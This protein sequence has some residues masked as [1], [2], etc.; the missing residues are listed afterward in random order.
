MIESEACHNLDELDAVDGLAG[1]LP[2][3]LEEL[4]V[5]ATVAH[6]RTHAPRLTQ[7]PW[8]ISQGIADY[9]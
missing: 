2:G 5:Q 9:D 7:H 8:G 3:G 4:H 1:L 6:A